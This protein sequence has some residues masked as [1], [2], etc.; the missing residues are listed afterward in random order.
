MFSIKKSPVKG[1]AISP[2]RDN[3]LSMVNSTDQKMSRVHQGTGYISQN[4]V[5][6]ERQEPVIHRPKIL[7]HV[8]RNSSSTREISNPSHLVSA[9]E[10][11]PQPITIMRPTTNDA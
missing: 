8:N 11:I 6:L 5:K 3:R 4:I 2:H 7:G 1:H 9:K 10:D